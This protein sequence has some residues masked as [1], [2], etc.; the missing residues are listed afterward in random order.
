MKKRLA[1]GTG[2]HRQLATG[3][4]VLKAKPGYRNRLTHRDYGLQCQGY[5]KRHLARGIGVL[6]QLATGIGV[7]KNTYG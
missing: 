4:G 7:L 6:R 2:V 5:R 3:T 1:S